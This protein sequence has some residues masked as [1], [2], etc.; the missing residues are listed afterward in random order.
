[1]PEQ[2]HLE[3]A[4]SALLVMDYQ[5]ILLENY[6]AEER[7]ATVLGQ[8]AKLLAAARAAQMPVIYV[9]VAFRSGH[10]EVSLRNRMFSFVKDNGLFLRDQATT[11]IH[12]DVAP[13]ESEPVVI[14]QR[15]GAFTG[16][17]L[18]MLLRA[19]G[20]ETLVLTGI[21]TAG[22]VL[23]T[24]RQAF[25]LDYRLIVASDCCADPDINVHDVLLEKIISHHA[26]V[27][28]A[29]RIVDAFATKN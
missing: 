11:A 22:V 23:S 19:K 14:K 25:D 2:L 13:L 10:P 26:E 17:D 4:K 3:P 27:V 20:I 8:T 16:T 7:R 12:R 28:Q 24:V 5:E 15:I 21:T 18:G 6:V 29:Q 9:I 1:M